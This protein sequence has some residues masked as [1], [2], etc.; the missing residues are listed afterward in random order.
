[1]KIQFLSYC[2]GECCQRMFR[3]WIHTKK[4]NR[5]IWYTMTQNT[6][7]TY[8]APII[9]H[10][11]IICMFIY[12]KLYLAYKYIFFKYVLSFIVS[13]V[14]IVNKCNPSVMRFSILNKLCKMYLSINN[15]YYS[16]IYKCIGSDGRTECC[17]YYYKYEYRSTLYSVWQLQSMPYCFLFYKPYMVYTRMCVLYIFPS[18]TSKMYSLC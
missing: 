11:F 18:P 15:Q 10:T 4:W 16:H 5:H 9:V 3:S 12:C 17:I 7:S 6:K 1:M 14:C 13:V 2:L 8:K